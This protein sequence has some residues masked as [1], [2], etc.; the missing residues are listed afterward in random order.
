[1]KKLT[2]DVDG[3]RVESFETSRS[4]EAMTGT[5]RAHSELVLTRWY[6][7]TCN[8]GV[9]CAVACRTRYDTPCYE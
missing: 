6:E 8:G 3:L 9:S 2:L 4:D 1:M 5:V 7:P